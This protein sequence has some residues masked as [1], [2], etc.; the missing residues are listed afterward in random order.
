MVQLTAVSSDLKPFIILVTF[1]NQFEI[2]KLEMAYE[3]V[4]KRC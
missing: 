2:F 1:I 3:E 4:N